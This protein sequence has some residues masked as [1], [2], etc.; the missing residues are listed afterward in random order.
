[1]VMESNAVQQCACPSQ[2]CIK[3]LS[4]SSSYIGRGGLN[5][6]VFRF[7]SQFARRVLEIEREISSY[8]LTECDKVTKSFDV[9]AIPPMIHL[10]PFPKHFLSLRYHSFPQLF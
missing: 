4:L 6:H 8:Y 10:A 7:Y 5:M 2:N 1:M 3:E 9:N